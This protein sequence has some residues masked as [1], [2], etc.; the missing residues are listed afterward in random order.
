MRTTIG[1]SGI[2]CLGL[3]RQCFVV[4]YFCFT[5]WCCFTVIVSIH[6]TGVNIEWSMFT[7]LAMVH[8]PCNTEYYLS[9]K[10]NFILL[11]NKK[12]KKD[13]KKI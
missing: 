5:V 12:N 10:A 4:V 8:K 7:M 1:E 3:Y 13:S 11:K 9:F 6:K 2:F